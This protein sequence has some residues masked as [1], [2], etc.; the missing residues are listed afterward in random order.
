MPT[1][2]SE[3]RGALW[4]D[5]GELSG[6]EPRQLADPENLVGC[7]VV[8]HGRLGAQP[9]ANLAPVERRWAPVGSACS[10]R[11][12][13]VVS[14]PELSSLSQVRVGDNGLQTC[15][16]IRACPLTGILL[17]PEDTKYHRGPFEDYADAVMN[18][19]Q[20]T[21]GTN[22]NGLSYLRLKHKY[23]IQ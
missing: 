3:T 21:T 9:G 1:C 19:C 11:P 20:A 7:V 10:V 18:L 6:D 16:S 5:E 15:Y 22:L 2:A 8:D 13:L 17:R 12:I 14:R 23:K 4:T